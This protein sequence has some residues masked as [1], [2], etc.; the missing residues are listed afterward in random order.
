MPENIAA[1]MPDDLHVYESND[2]AIHF[3]KKE[4]FT[5]KKEQTDEETGQKELEMSWRREDS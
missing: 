4:G 1:F 3:Y 5:V 2:R